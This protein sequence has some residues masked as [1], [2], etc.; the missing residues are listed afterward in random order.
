VD[1][2]ARGELRGWPAR[3]PPSTMGNRGGGVPALTEK[4]GKK[5]GVWLLYTEEA[6]EGLEAACVSGVAGRCDTRRSIVF[7]GLGDCS[8]EI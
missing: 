3:R 6:R 2:V 1:V 4:V 8:F 5:V 7:A